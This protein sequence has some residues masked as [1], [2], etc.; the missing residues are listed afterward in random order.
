M[1]GKPGFHHAQQR[2]LASQATLAAPADTFEATAIPTVN[3]PPGVAVEDLPAGALLPARADDPEVVMA[4]FI[5]AAA[6][7]DPLEAAVCL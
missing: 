7:S 2:R 5:V 1:A 3:A 4:H 6:A